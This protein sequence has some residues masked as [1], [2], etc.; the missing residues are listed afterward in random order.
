[1]RKLF[2]R[3][4]QGPV[5]RDREQLA[6][7][8]ALRELAGTER[9]LVYD[10]PLDARPVSE[11]GRL[12][13]RGSARW[14]RFLDAREVMDSGELTLVLA[15][16]K[17][18][19]EEARLA[20]DWGCT[21]ANTFLL[22]EPT[23]DEC[24]L[25]DPTN[26][27][28]LHLGDALREAAARGAAARVG[29]EPRE[30]IEG[31]TLL[32]LLRSA[33]GTWVYWTAPPPDGSIQR[34]RLDVTVSGETLAGRLLFE[35]ERRF[36]QAEFDHELVRLHLLERE[37]LQGPVPRARSVFRTRLGMPVLLDPFAPD[38]GLRR[39]VDRGRLS[40]TETRLADRVVYG[41]GRPVPSVVSDEEFA[42][43]AV[44]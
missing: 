32:A 9:G 12:R 33:F 3:K 6:W 2:Q 15:L 10:V 42:R 39:L 16:R 14:E 8:T 19:D 27:W 28:T 11:V 5:E 29:A 36:Q 20:I 34:V 7:L 26:Q 41:P 35:L 4:T 31:T 24:D 21:Y 18:D 40:V 30:W 17:L 37:L 23:D 13:P 25:G 44:M 22:V 43:L 38:R 1:M